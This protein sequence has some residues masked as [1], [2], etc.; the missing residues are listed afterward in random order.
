M[1]DSTA[2]VT[3]DVRLNQSYEIEIELKATMD[4]LIEGVGFDYVHPLI[5]TLAATERGVTPGQRSFRLIHPDLVLTDRFVREELKRQHLRPAKLADL[6]FLV[7]RYPNLC[8]G[9]Q[10]VALGSPFWQSS[11]AV[12]ADVPIIR[13]NDGRMR[14]AFVPLSFAGDHYYLGIEEAA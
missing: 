3:D 11:D 5:N 2:P 6:I 7:R 14:L 13:C 4:S 8:E 1:P 10:V 9:I 12:E